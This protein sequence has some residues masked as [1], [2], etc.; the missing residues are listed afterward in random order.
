MQ[1]RPTCLEPDPNLIFL[2]DKEKEERDKWVADPKNWCP[3][4]QGRRGVCAECK[5]KQC[6]DGRVEATFVCIIC[7]LRSKCKVYQKFKNKKPEIGFADR[8]NFA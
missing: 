5:I 7:N 8:L 2:T 6:P 1:G 4:A 3:V